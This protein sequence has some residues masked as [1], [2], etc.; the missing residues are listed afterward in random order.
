[1]HASNKRY[2]I[3]TSPYGRALG[4]Q[5][6]GSLRTSLALPVGARVEHT[7]SLSRGEG[8]RPL[9]GLPKRA[10]DITVASVVLVLLLPMMLIVTVLIRIFMGGPAIFAQERIGFGGRV[11]I[12]YKFRTMVTNG[13]EVLRRYLDAKPEAAREWKETRKL[14][15]DPRVGC[16]G[17]VLRKSSIDELPQLFNVL[18]GD[19]SL[20]GPRPV[21]PDELE[22]YGCHTE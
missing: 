22:Y 17:N 16:L 12:C 4:K 14:A 5:F 1:M 18:R 10:L 21:V 8:Q 15:N 7:A 11:F 9:G 3:E 2:S 20:V 13:E 19:M 6:E